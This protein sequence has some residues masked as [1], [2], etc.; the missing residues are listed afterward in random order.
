MILGNVDDCIVNDKLPPSEKVF[1]EH[2]KQLSDSE[3]LLKASYGLF[4]CEMLF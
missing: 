4:A 3:V 2:V 1:F